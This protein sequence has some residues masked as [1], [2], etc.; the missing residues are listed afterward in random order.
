MP[1]NLSMCV[2]QNVTASPVDMETNATYDAEMKELY[3][4]ELDGPWTAGSP[5]SV[6][7][8]PISTFTNRSQELLSDYAS[9]DPAAFLRPG[10]DSRVIAG[11]EAQRQVL[12]TSLSTPNIAAMEFI[13]LSGANRRIQMP[14]SVSVQHPFSR[15]FIEINSTDPWEAPIIDFRTGSNPVDLDL[16]VEGMKFSRKIVA[17]PAIQELLPMEMTPGAMIQSDDELKA[18]LRRTVTTMFHPS[19][20]AAMM[21][22]ELGGVVRQVTVLFFS[23][24][25]LSS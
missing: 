15:G 22:R 5:N 14:L 25:F 7:F 18:F 3:Y 12:L 1:T 23:L 6:A 19:G 10:L 2:V 16:Y 9:Q 17:T 11:F 24:C 20:T 8:L 13:W 4:T 21:K